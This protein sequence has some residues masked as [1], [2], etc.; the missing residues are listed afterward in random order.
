M[1]SHY[2]NLFRI[3]YK[4]TQS[5]SFNCTG[6][7]AWCC[8]SEHWSPEL[9]GK[10][11]AALTGMERRI[12]LADFICFQPILFFLNLSPETHT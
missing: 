12:N 11:N 6:S 9:S 4:S 5:G 3:S 10:K 8:A 7:P 1:V 2:C